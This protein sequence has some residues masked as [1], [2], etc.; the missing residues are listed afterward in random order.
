M[1][2]LR[3][4]GTLLSAFDQPLPPFG[5]LQRDDV[6]GSFAELAVADGHAVV[7]SPDPGAAFLAWASVVDNRSDDPLFLLALPV[8]L[9]GG[10]R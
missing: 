5:F 1:D 9:A 3:S 10:G 8:D 4:D 2:L 6:L 7:S